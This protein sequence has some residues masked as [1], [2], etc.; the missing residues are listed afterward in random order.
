MNENST[1]FVPQEIPKFRF[2]HEFKSTNTNLSIIW[3][4]F[5]DRKQNSFF[6]FENSKWTW[7]VDNLAENF[8]QQQQI[9]QLYK[10]KEFCSLIEKMSK[11]RVKQMG[12]LWCEHLRNEIE[13]KNVIF[14]VHIMLLWIPFVHRDWGFP[15]RLVFGKRHIQVPFEFDMNKSFSCQLGLTLMS[16]CKN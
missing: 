1:L 11:N 10:F 2:S 5:V 9:F 14:P 4:T 7:A 12:K 16:W 8:Q 15:H 6:T 3:R 13:L